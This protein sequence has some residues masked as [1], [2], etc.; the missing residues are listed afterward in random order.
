M[1]RCVCEDKE[2]V[3]VCVSRL[4]EDGRVVVSESVCVCV[5]VCLVALG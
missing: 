3:C 5:C 4:G 1:A 2:R